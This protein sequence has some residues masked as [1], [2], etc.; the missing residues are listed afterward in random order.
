MSAEK[1]DELGAAQY[2]IKTLRTTEELK[3]KT[4]EEVY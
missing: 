1:D 4:V 3:D 2:E